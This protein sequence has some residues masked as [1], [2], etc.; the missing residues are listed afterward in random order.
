MP[1]SD[2]QD[3]PVR[4]ELRIAMEELAD[5]VRARNPAGVLAKF[6][7]QGFRFV[8]SRLAK[9]APRAIGF[10]RLERELNAGKGELYEVLFG[11]GGVIEYV[12]GKRQ[13]AWPAVA[14][15]EFMPRHV[16]DKKISLRF[17]LEGD[18]WL[19]DTL[20]FPATVRA[21]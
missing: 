15:D 21:R 10:E 2:Q 20:A 8:D 5:A 14:A 19:V 18:A 7:R 16:E 17:R 3:V 11:A 13:V 9:P 12:S 4:A 6:S 1:V